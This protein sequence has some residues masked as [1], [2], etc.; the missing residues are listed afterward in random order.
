MSL[1]VEYGQTFGPRNI[2]RT[3]GAAD[4]V[5]ACQFHP[6]YATPFWEINDKVYYFSDV[7]PPL[8]TSSNGRD[9]F[10]P[11]VDTSLNGTSFQCFVPSS[12]GND[13]IG[14]S[15]GV[16]TVIE[17]GKCNTQPITQ[18]H[19]TPVVISFIKIIDTLGNY[20]IQKQQHPSKDKLTLDHQ[21]FL[22]TADSFTL[23]WSL[24]SNE[25]SGYY[26]LIAGSN[27]ATGSNRKVLVNSTES[28]NIV[29]QP[30]DLLDET[31]SSLHIN[32][33][34]FD[35]ENVALLS[36]ETFQFMFGSKF[37]SI[38]FETFP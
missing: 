19:Y 27:C 6:A 8:M 16:L 12:S 29:L 26:K 1:Y 21:R 11:I 7:P 13:L 4:V 28:V 17:T 9:I 10:I 25:T 35:E 32:I 18:A 5:I 34:L 14:S 3:E 36:L 22:F 31:N 37:R 20:P 15:V 33:T 2:T 30:G 23:A 38:V 24:S